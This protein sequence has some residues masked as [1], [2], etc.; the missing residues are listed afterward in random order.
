MERGMDCLVG[1]DGIGG[2]EVRWGTWSWCLWRQVLISNKTPVMR[3][4]FPHIQIA[5]M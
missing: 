3:S 4:L 5:V 1:V 2:E